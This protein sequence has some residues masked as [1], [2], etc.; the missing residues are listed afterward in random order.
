MDIVAWLRELGL[1]RYAEAFAEGDIDAEVLPDL[2]E[3]DLERLGVSLGHRKKLMRAI[4][5]LGER[6]E[7]EMPVAS[8]SAP[9]HESAELRH[10]TVLFCDIVGSTDLAQRLD[11]EDMAAV[12]RAYRACCERM[13]ARWEGHLNHFVGDGA[14]VFFGYPQAHEDDAIRAAHAGLEL[15]QAIRGLEIDPG[16]DC[17]L[18]ARVGI[19]T[20]LVLAGELES[21]DGAGGVV[22]DTM[23][24]AARLQTLAEPDQV[25]VGDQTH[26]LLGAAFETVSL[27]APTLKGFAKPVEVWRVDSAG[28]RARSRF[29]ARAAG[30][31]TPFSG[32]EGEIAT[33]GRL[34]SAARTGSG[35]IALLRGD[36]GIGKSRIFHEFGQRL[37]REPHAHVALHCSPYHTSSAWHPVV[38]WIER[39][40]DFRDGDDAPARLAKLEALLSATVSTPSTIVPWIA[41]LLSIDL[42]DQPQPR[43]LTPQ[44]IKARTIAALCDW[45]E[46]SAGQQPLLLSVEDAH[47]LDASSKEF[48][49]VVA[50]S[51]A[52]MPVFML[53]TSRGDFMSEWNARENFTAIEIGR[54]DTGA[55]SA[56][57]QRLTGS[58]PMQP[59]LAR[60]LIAKADGVPLFLEELARMVS[61]APTRARESDDIAAAPGGELGVPDTLKDL[62]TA[63][64]DRLGPA[65]EVAQMGAVI[66]REFDHDVLSKAMGVAPA[67]L[68]EALPWLVEA[69]LVYE[70]ARGGPRRY[71]FRHALVRDAAYDSLPK[72]RRK[73]L[74]RQLAEGIQA[75]FPGL[76]QAKPELVAQHYAGAG[77]ADLA[78]DSWLR[79]GQR[80]LE[81]SAL[82]EAVE[83]LH[84]GLRQL[85]KLEPGASRDRREL[86][87]FRALAP[88][89]LTTRG[90]GSEEAGEAFERL[91]ALCER[92][93]DDLGLFLA[94]R[95]LW[96]FRF[97]RAELFVAADLAE[98]LLAL[99][100]DDESRSIEAHRAAGMTALYRGDFAVAAG[101]LEEGVALYDRERHHHHAYRYGNDPGV[102]CLS[103]GAKALWC[104]GRAEEAKARSSAAL[105]LARELEHPFSRSQAL[106]LAGMLAQHHRDVDRV[107][108]LAKEAISSSAAYSF[109]YWM[110]AGSILHA[111]ARSQ[112]D[113][114]RETVEAL[115]EALQDYRASGAELA[116]PWFMA[117]SAEARGRIGDRER[118]LAL[119]EEA[120]AR[121]E[122]TG[123]CY[124]LAEILRLR[125]DLLSKTGPDE[126]E[127]A[128]RRAIGVAEAQ[129]AR[130]W[131]RRARISLARLLAGAG[132]ATEARE[133]LSP[134]LTDVSQTEDSLDVEAARALMGAL[135]DRIN[136]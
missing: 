21:M 17:R 46:S 81:R 135:P 64:L 132:R 126:A 39:A 19:A 96:A 30:R 123:E 25:V 117:L 38:D 16:I 32:R 69:E 55:A 12:Y 9:R 84:Q 95:G 90:Y 87:L 98:Q 133:A 65:K 1:E 62:L 22:G 131:A 70:I 47:W 76:A 83:Q 86:E 134:V 54:L 41:R 27:G 18:R 29:E 91:R 113:E 45:I 122:A 26:R 120:E 108:E 114:T 77:L 73:E 8:G 93:G 63:R 85:D 10:L 129:Q 121:G 66:G 48:L 103:Y 7:P 51:L 115:D 125:G 130:A 57:M 68:E 28:S 40:A 111:W 112:T 97:V 92:V 107:M 101:H 31:L 60:R 74:H 5:R 33:L 94:L 6:S 14:V 13:V 24:L 20:G 99:A 37:M 35:Q 61:E 43:G 23:N 49:E 72:R 53:V 4:A 59:E 2:T 102:V 124:Y 67:K 118:A 50:D 36:A 119:L 42:P 78:V 52:V 127:T 106:A 80:A 89:L 34:W 82:V 136:G 58:A 15:V 75:K 56:M 104:L 79:A 110:A 88:A 71:V 3:A 116:V 11:P 44:M 105:E 109:R 100:E 128:Y